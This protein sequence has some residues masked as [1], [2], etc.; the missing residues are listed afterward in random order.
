MLCCCSLVI[1]CYCLSVVA[2][3]SVVV[4]SVSDCCYCR[5]FVDIDVELSVLLLDCIILYSLYDLCQ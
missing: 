1:G 5:G 4:L 2:I 3:V